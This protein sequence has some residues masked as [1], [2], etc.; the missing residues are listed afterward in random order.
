MDDMIYMFIGAL[1]YAL[2][3]LLFSFISMRFIFNG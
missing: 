2:G 1:I 3:I